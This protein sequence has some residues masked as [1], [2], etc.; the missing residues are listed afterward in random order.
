MNN[1]NNLLSKSGYATSELAKKFIYSDTNEK[2]KTV[3]EYSKEIGVSRGTIQNSIKYLIDN[4][5]INLLSR[6]QLGTFIIEKDIIGLFKIAGINF[7]IGSMPLPYSKRYEGLST[8]IIQSIENN[9]K[10]PINMT[11]MRGSKN[12]I[13]MVLNGRYDFTITS[14][15]AA[16]R[17]IQDNPDLIIA[18]ELKHQSFLSKH[19]LMFKNPNFKTIEDEMTAGIDSDSLDQETLT[20]LLCKDKNVNIKKISYNQLV[21]NLESGKI[22]FAVWNGDELKDKYNQIITKDLDVDDSI[23]TIAVIIV[24]KDNILIKKIIEDFIDIEFIEEIQNKVINNIIIP[25]Y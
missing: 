8:A 13:N 5:L 6:G 24:H 22:D 18:K 25:S 16:L 2:I 9:I 19:V 17:F 20:Y 14:K 7:I 1:K 15:F 12:R 23:N 3:T 11:Y 4:K 21:E 10:I